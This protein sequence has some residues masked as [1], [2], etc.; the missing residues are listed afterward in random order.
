MKMDTKLVEQLVSELNALLQAARG[1]PETQK[2][3]SSPVSDKQRKY[4]FALADRAGLGKD[5]LNR[6]IK[7]LTG[8]DSLDSC[9]KDEASSVIDTLSEIVKKKTIKKEE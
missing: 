5:A 1:K 7:Q 2:K 8:K 6:L 3:A 9:S 4:V